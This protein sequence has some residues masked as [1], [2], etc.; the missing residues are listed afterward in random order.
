[1]A[2]QRHKWRRTGKE[3]VKYSWKCGRC[4]KH[5]TRYNNDKHPP[6][7]G[8]SAQ[9]GHDP[10]KHHW[11]SPNKTTQHEKKCTVCGLTRYE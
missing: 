4:A 7:S 11:G 1:M 6:Y 3:R 9:G 8:C 10:G 5:V 2:C